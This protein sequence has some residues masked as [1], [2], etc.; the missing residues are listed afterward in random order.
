M[1]DEYIADELIKARKREAELEQRIAD[2]ID[3]VIQ[4]QLQRDEAR[5][6][7]KRLAA[8]IE[9]AQ[10]IMAAAHATAD[11]RTYDLMRTIL[12]DVA[13]TECNPGGQPWR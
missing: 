7:V 1:G 6:E 4:L 10:D 8:V 3:T 2:N 9:R 12:G 5:E 11:H 13:R